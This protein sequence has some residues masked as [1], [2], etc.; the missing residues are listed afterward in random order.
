MTET[1][2]EPYYKMRRR[3]VIATLALCVIVAA[4][5]GVY[6]IGRLRR[7]PA[8][9]ACRGAVDTA[10]RVAPLVHGEVA[11]LAVASTPFR[12]PALAFKD[13]EGRDRTLA[14]WR[15][16]TVL[17]NLWATWCVPCVAEMPALQAMAK[18]LAGEGILVLPLSSDRGGAPVVRGFYAAHGI[19]SLPIWLDPKG[20]AMQAWGAQ[21]LPTS[22]VIDRQGRE[23]GRLEG[24]VDWSADA[25]LYAIRRLVG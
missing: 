17:L 4:V 19:D 20:A 18:K 10:S 22:L 7:N 2:A 15:G 11:A 25:T 9:A 8:D 5:A 3:R 6:G 24:A 16:R 12:V 1:P 14:D 23:Q 13:A 21:G